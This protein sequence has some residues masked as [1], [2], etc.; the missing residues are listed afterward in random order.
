ML[1]DERRKTSRAAI[2]PFPGDPLLFD[3]WYKLFKN[4]WGTEVDKLYVY[5]NSP[6][7][8][9][10]VDY[11]KAKLKEDIEAGKVHLEYHPEQ[12]EHGEVI[13]RSL[14][15]ITEE[16]VMLVEDDGFIF[17]KGF[18]SQCFNWL[19][20]GAYDI[21]GS[22]RGSCGMEVLQA[23]Q[24]KYGISYEGEGD[25]GPN[26]WPCYFFAKK[27]LYLKT[28]RNF[29]AKAWPA[30]TKIEELDH[31]CTIDQAGDTFVQASLQLRNIV[32]EERI[33]YV[34]QYHA[35]PLD[36]D[37]YKQRKYVFD[38]QAPWIHIGSLSSGVGG[39]L[40]DEFSRPL[41]RRTVDPQGPE[42]KLTNPPTSDF[43]A[44]E[45]ERRVAWWDTFYW[46]SP[47]IGI[48]EFKRLYGD[49]VH[50]VIRQYGLNKKR[51]TERKQAFSTLINGELK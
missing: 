23:A 26:F 29:G 22:K 41:A 10:V 35:H 15:L 37:H 50:R 1:K 43:E 6:V 7:E 30:G 2:L 40:K 8:K 45:W 46:Q 38:G 24:K 4:V 18:V 33:K 13:N 34:P 44:Q 21:V 12:L 11:I 9:D 27:E 5:L 51:I 49:A 39:V 20:C 16:Y 32:P 47:A 25:Q 19:E 28:N 31:V 14:D 42:T 48:A 17:K 36:L 3:Y